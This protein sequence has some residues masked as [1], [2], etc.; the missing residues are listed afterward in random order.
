MSAV[1][2]CIELELEDIVTKR[3]EYSEAC[4]YSSDQA[5]ELVYSN[6]AFWLVRKFAEE[7]L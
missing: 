5:R 6:F 1:V 3:L 7:E 4:G 2:R